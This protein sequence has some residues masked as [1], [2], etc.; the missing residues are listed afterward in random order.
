M[1]KQEKSAIGFYQSEKLL[2]HSGIGHFFSTKNGD[3]TNL[4]ELDD[5]FNLKK[6]FLVIGKQTHS[7]EIEIITSANK[8]KDFVGVD[9][10]ITNEKGICIAVKTADCTPVLLFDP[11]QK[12]VAAIHSGW[13]GTVQNITGKTIS[14][15]SEE[16]QVQPKNIIAAIGPCIGHRNYEVGEEV[17]IQFRELFSCNPAIIFEANA[18]HLKPKISVRNAIQ[19]QLLNSGVQPENIEV[20]EECTFDNGA[21]FHSARREGAKTGRLINGIWLK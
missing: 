19:Q 14:K 6:S 20:S 5:V 1:I 3:F 12:V 7:D 21:D 2:Q 8:S 9:A 10:Y 13:R 16:F 17:A 18:S 11:V 4:D 15:I